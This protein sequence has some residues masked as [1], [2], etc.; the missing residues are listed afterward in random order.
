MKT[1]ETTTHTDI[2]LL[3]PS[4]RAVIVLDST[5]TEEHLK[6]LVKKSAEI[7]AVE[8]KEAREQAHRVGMEL[9]NARTT[10]QKTGKTAREDATAFSKAVIDEEKRLIAITEGEESRVIGLRDDFD[11]KV[12]A[13]KAAAE[14][15]EKAR[16]D[17]ILGQIQGIRNLPLAMAHATAEEIA[18]EV[19]ALAAFEPDPA[20]F[21]EFMEDLAHAI[22]DTINALEA[23]HARVMA[24]EAAKAALAAERQ[25]L[26]DERARMAAEREEMERMRAEM[27]AMKA[28]QD[29]AN[30]VVEPV[31]DVSLETTDTPNE[32]DPGFY[33]Q[34]DGVETDTHYASGAPKFSSTS[35]RDDGQ[36]IMLNEDGTRSIFCDVDEGGEVVDAAFESVDL[37]GEVTIISFE[38]RQFALATAAQFDALADKCDACGAAAFAK[39]LRAV[40]YGLREGDHDRVIADADVQALKDADNRLID[41][42]VN[43][44]DAWGEI[45]QAAE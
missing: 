44:I 12:A 9:K 39:E 24:A 45:A 35:F 1:T 18:S 5:K 28:A 7:T 10:I 30:T 37:S 13:E 15:A 21:A 3:P 33:M 32:D 29:A 34:S 25:A 27:A 26:E 43:A 40:S 11:A 20:V 19:N 8:S 42:T 38:V 17:A 16:K 2:A 22:K 31:A 4:E 14:A 6:E 36:P 41:A 23:L